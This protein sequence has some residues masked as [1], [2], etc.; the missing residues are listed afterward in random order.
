MLAAARNED[1][2][3]C[4]G[5]FSRHRCA[6]QTVS[7]SQIGSEQPTITPKPFE[8]PDCERLQAPILG[9]GYRPVNHCNN[10]GKR[11]QRGELSSLFFG[12]HTSCLIWYCEGRRIMV[13]A[14]A[15]QTM[16]PM[17]DWTK[18][19]K[20]TIGAAVEP[21][22]S[23]PDDR[24]AVTTAIPDDLTL[25]KLFN[26]AR[27]VVALTG[28]RFFR[29]LVRNLAS[30]LGTRYA[31]VAEFPGQGTRVRTLAFWGGDDFFD[32]LEFELAGTP[33]QDVIGG[34]L[35]YHP[36]RVSALFPKDRPL[37]AM[38]VEGYLGVPLLGS[39]GRVLGHL[40][41][42]DTKSLAIDTELVSTLQLFASRA[43]MEL[44]RL[45]AE[46]RLR[47]SEKRLATVVGSA[48]D[49]II[50]I[51][52]ERRITLFNA[53][54]EKMFHCR[55]DATIGQTFDQFLSPRFRE[56]FEGYL[57]DV[58]RPGARKRALWAPGGLS[59]V[60]TGGGEFPIEATISPLELAGRRLFTL[61]LRD[62]NERKEAQQALARLQLE[63]AYLH[64]ELESHQKID[65]IIGDSSAMKEVFRNLAQVAP[66][67][68][69]VLITG[70]T[71]TGKELVARAIHKLS[72]RKGKI[73]VNL[74]CAALPRELVESE[75][76][77]HEKGAFTGAIQQKKGRFELADGGTWWQIAV[78]TSAAAR[79]SPALA[80]YPPQ[81]S[82]SFR[83]I[84]CNYRNIVPHDRSRSRTAFRPSP[85]T[86]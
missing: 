17:A 62:V 46:T 39:D 8:T 50:T 18:N 9:D 5:I 83:D 25:G 38:A 33:C 16:D 13:M 60:R 74:N 44:E 78:S 77:G 81:P 29:E 56:F 63:N 55:A 3:L 12:Q 73:L 82:S 72:G 32:N 27:G 2:R 31:F 65:E 86:H 70:E 26:I 23:R 51:D 45:R 53:A 6:F 14:S 68:S 85:I 1:R 59:A 7:D 67:D 48:M 34:K 64:E 49:A 71:G 84:W 54:A 75:L 20:A 11:A 28:E 36:E 10:L 42:M 61:I 30:T 37:A 80:Q 40:A 35:T 76:F 15:L 24:L 21:Q 43:C 69:T 22:S 57:Q 47:D 52:D 58:G 4:R 79:E 19:T 41:L 66:T